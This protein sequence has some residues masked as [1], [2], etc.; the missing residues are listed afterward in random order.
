MPVK[1]AR[2]Y[3]QSQVAPSLRVVAHGVES[4]WHVLR[5]WEGDQSGR[6]R[7]AKKVQLMLVMHR[8]HFGS[9]VVRGN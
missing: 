9:L 4:I 7:S 8:K 6:T 2:R 3:Q 1:R 5:L